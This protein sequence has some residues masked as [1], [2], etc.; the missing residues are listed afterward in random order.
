M[1]KQENTVELMTFDV[2]KFDITRAEIAE[3]SQKG[4]TLTIQGLDDK[5]GFDAVHAALMD[6]VHRRAFIS[7]QGLAYRRKALDWNAAVLK[8]EKELVALIQPVEDYLTDLENRVKEEKARIKKEAEEK[9]LAII[10]AR[11]DRLLDMGCRFDRI[12]NAYSYGELVA[13]VAMIKVAPDDMFE[14]IC[15]AIQGAVDADKAEKAA[16]ET[17]RL[18]EQALILKVQQEQETERQRQAEER[19]RLALEGKAIQEAKDAI[20][21]EKKAAEDAILKAEQDKL[22]AIELE[23]AK[24]EAAEKATKETAERIQRETEAKWA[25]EKADADAKLAKELKAKEAAERKAARAPDREK[26]LGFVIE[27]ECKAKPDFR[28]EE[29]R[30][31]LDEFLNGLSALTKSLRE[32]AEAL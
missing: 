20:A 15:V 10:Q 4:M 27:F 8:E 12:A 18:E 2:V 32:K 22:R 28:T 13:P 7:K 29:A 23:K 30:I 3:I 5:T 17:R 26:L 25:K 6:V 16:E 19:E 1:T 9:I 21:R 24:T 31:I 14:K 11:C